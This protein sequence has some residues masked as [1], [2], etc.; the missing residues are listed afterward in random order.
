MTVGTM[1]Q[2]TPQTGGPSLKRMLIGMLLGVL[3]PLAIVL[4]SALLAPG[5][6]LTK[7]CHITS[8]GWRRSP[9]LEGSAWDVRV[10]PGGAVWASTFPPSRLSRL[11]NGAWRTYGAQ[12][13]GTS[14]AAEVHDFVL[15]GE[16]VLAA[17]S[18]GVILFDGQRW[19]LWPEAINTRSLSS[20]VAA[21][22][23]IYAVDRDGDLSR[24]SGGTWRI[25]RIQLP[26]V[27]WD[28]HADPK[29]AFAGDSV[30]LI[31]QGL[32]RLDGATW[33]PADAPSVPKQAQFAGVA[34]DHIWL[35]TENKLWELDSVGDLLRSY[36]AADLGLPKNA[37]LLQVAS[38][39]GRTVIANPEGLV[40]SDGAGWRKL[41][42]PG[43]TLR[44][45][46]RFDIAPDG[47]IWMIGKIAQFGS[48]R[49]A[50]VFVVVVLAVV[51]IISKSLQRR[52]RT[53]SDPISPGGPR[54]YD[55]RGSI[56]SALPALVF[57]AL[58]QTVFLAPA[59][60]RLILGLVLMLGLAF[61]F[62]WLQQILERKVDRAA[63]LGQ[64]DLALKLAAYAAR[65][66]ARRA[67]NRGDVLTDAGRYEEAESA[68]R[69]AIERAPTPTYGALALANLASGLMDQGRYG[70]AQHCL[71]GATKILPERAK[72]PMIQAEIL[73]RQGVASREAL[74]CSERAVELYGKSQLEQRACPQRLGEI[75]ATRA[76]ALA[77]V[78]RRG[79]ALGFLNQ[80]LASEAT[81]WN[82]SGAH[83][84]YNAAMALRILG[85]ESGADEHLKRGRDTNPNGRWGKLCAAALTA[86]PRGA[87]RI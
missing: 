36:E 70:E 59:K 65:N 85:D 62:Q 63:L 7:V 18:E 84:H 21:R 40:E 38:H 19:Q 47:S 25:S 67:L 6:P 76:W 49:F 42:T 72:N 9:A 11:D 53:A 73:L 37:G 48:T 15:D 2:P 29:L 5:K 78:G 61:V 20:V 13:F 79:E 30:W 4:A 34:R 77:A 60:W 31:S 87:T 66:A 83:V 10:S 80:A 28:P 26:G 33:Q 16:R 8:I 3:L 58:C 46:V 52:Q 27:V 81:K 24:Y 35:T 75:L 41:W 71:E 23:E 45:I 32:W 17:T 51:L 82:H 64:Y 69:E 12:D 68:L 54:K 14:P 1:V 50:G 43:L 56:Q 55:L 44:G 22:D 74:A 57:L 86:S 39:D